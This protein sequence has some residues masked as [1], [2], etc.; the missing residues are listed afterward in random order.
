MQRRTERSEGQHARADIPTALTNSEYS[1]PQPSHSSDALDCIRGRAMHRLFFFSYPSE[2]FF[3]LSFLH[4]GHSLNNGKRK[5]K[6]YREVVPRGWVRVVDGLLTDCMS[7]SL[8]MFPPAENA[9][10]GTVR[11]EFFFQESLEMLY[12]LLIKKKIFS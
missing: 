10:R 12:L 1:A 2:N 11:F 4:A 8:I 5:N 9:S 6:G 7:G 3:S